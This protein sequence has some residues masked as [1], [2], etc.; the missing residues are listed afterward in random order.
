MW[1]TQT[2]LTIEAIYKGRT[3][4]EKVVEGTKGEPFGTSPIRFRYDDVL[5]DELYIRGGDDEVPGSKNQLKITQNF[6]K[7]FENFFT[8]P[9]K[10]NHFLKIGELEI[11]LLV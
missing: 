10:D 9:D 5:I 4:D 7:N 3:V 8:T 1:K 11:D 6:R 2:G